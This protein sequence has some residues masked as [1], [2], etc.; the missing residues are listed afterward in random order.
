MLMLKRYERPPLI[1][2]AAGK[3]VILL[4]KAL[5]LFLSI[6]FVTRPKR[7]KVRKFSI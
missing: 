6:L 3:R 2:A 4:F 7:E 5:T 1:R